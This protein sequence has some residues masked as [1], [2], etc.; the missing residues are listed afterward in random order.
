MEWCH[1]LF[2]F[3]QQGNKHVEIV[4]LSVAENRMIYKGEMFV[5][6]RLVEKYA[7]E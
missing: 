4:I 6:R 5:W 3:P 2:F 1:S 7:Q